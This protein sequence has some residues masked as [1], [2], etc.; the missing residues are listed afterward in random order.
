[1]NRV[2]GHGARLTTSLNVGCPR[3]DQ[4]LKF[5]WMKGYALI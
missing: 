4:V 2:H 5:K 1:M 3:L